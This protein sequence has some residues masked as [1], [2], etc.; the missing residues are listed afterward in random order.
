[1][2]WFRGADTLFMVMFSRALDGLMMTGCRAIGLYVVVY[3]AVFIVAPFVVVFD[4]WSVLPLWGWML[5]VVSADVVLALVAAWPRESVPLVAMNDHAAWPTV[6]PQTSIGASHR[7]GRRP[8][9]IHGFMRAS[10]TP[11]HR[12]VRFGHSRLR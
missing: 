12:R 5:F 9:V 3:A 1:M 10:V 11:M 6:R 4:A 7:M 2:A 8:R